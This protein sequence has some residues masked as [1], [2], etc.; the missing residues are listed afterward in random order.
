[1]SITLRLNGKPFTANV[2]TTISAL[3][4][5]HSLHPDH[6]VVEVNEQIIPR[7]DYATCTVSH[8]DVVEIL[9]FVGG[10]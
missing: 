4:L 1:M 6:V 2:D 3:L 10:G 9:R 8:D 5:E 7:S